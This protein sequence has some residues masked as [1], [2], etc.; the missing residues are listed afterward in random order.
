MHSRSGGQLHNAAG[1]AISL[2]PWQGHLDMHFR[3]MRHDLLADLN[4][5]VLQFKEQGGVR[6]LQASKAFE[7]QARGNCAV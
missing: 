3:L 1:D 2:E 6:K 7:A 5:S 4:D